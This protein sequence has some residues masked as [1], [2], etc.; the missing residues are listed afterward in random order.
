MID[1]LT[2][3]FIAGKIAIIDYAKM[4]DLDMDAMFYLLDKLTLFLC[5]SDMVRGVFDN[6]EYAKLGNVKTKDICHKLKSN[7]FQGFESLMKYRDVVI[8]KLQKYNCFIAF[9]IDVLWGKLNLKYSYNRV[10]T[11]QYTL[12]PLVEKIQSDKSMEFD[13]A[14][15]MCCGDIGPKDRLVLATCLVTLMRNESLFLVNEFPKSEFCDDELGKKLT[16]NDLV[17]FLNSKNSTELLN[18]LGVWTITNVYCG[19]L[20]NPNSIPLIIREGTSNEWHYR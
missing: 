6:S 3:D 1:L 16:N 11:K 20:G 13:N 18:L 8:D 12:S 10:K 14:I 17:F 2:K 19:L 7:E 5:S 9:A 4:H 15:T